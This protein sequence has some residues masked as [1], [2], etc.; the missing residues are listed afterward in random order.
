MPPYEC[1]VFFVQLL[2]A[3]PTFNLTKSKVYS[4]I[5]IEWRRMRAY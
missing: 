2:Q 1:I 4:I 3:N 5:W